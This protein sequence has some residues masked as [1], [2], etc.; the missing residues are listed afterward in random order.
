MRVLLAMNLEKKE[1]NVLVYLKEEQMREKVMAMLKENQSRKAFMFLKEK[2]EVEAIFPDGVRP[3]FLPA[4][5]LIED[6]VC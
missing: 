2:A 5:T 6:E 4:F 1:V 3:P